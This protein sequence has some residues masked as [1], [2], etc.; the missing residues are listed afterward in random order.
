MS[1]TRGTNAFLLNL[2]KDGTC[3]EYVF[4]G[5]YALQ[6]V[7]LLFCE[8]KTNAMAH[9]GIPPEVVLLR[10]LLRHCTKTAYLQHKHEQLK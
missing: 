9:L 3:G 7:W 10:V 5:Q 8:K 4:L 6:F 2:F 1:Y